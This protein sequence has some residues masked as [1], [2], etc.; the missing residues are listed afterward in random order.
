MSH[1]IEEIY[2]LRCVSNG[3]YD[4]L[5][6]RVKSNNNFACINSGRS[7]GLSEEEAVNTIANVFVNDYKSEYYK[8]KII[9]G[10]EQ[11]RL[12]NVT[13]ILS[14]DME[15]P[16]LPFEPHYS[17]KMKTVDSSTTDRQKNEVSQCELK[18]KLTEVDKDSK[19]VKFFEDKKCSVCLSNY[20]EIVDEDLHV[21]V[22]SCGHPLCCK[23]ADNILASEKK[24]CPQCRGNFTAQAFDLMEFNE[25]LTVKY[26]DQKIF[27]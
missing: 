6:L 11:L 8:E 14:D 17:C 2:L 9:E 27:L 1:S 21:V 25:N 7:S 3:Q 19:V 15:I 13:N 16:V 20:K 10:F 18:Q 26:N 23:C 22:P 5:I 4:Y 24:E 12:R